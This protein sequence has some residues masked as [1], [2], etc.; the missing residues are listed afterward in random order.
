MLTWST[1]Y[2]AVRIHPN[3]CI[4]ETGKVP[5]LANGVLP[6]SPL[7][8]ISNRSV[9]VKAVQHMQAL[10][11]TLDEMLPPSPCF[12]VR[13]SPPDYPSAWLLPSSARFP[14]VPASV[15]PGK[16]I[17][18]LCRSTGRC[19]RR[20]WQPNAWD[21][22]L[23]IGEKNGRKRS[24]LVDGIGVP[25]SLAVS[26]ANTHDVKLLEATLDQV[27]IEMPSRAVQSVRGCGI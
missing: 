16:E 9:H 11:R 13:M 14:A 12:I 20:H 15:S 19:T 26:G 1:V 22:T 25:L 24:L 17:L 4:R 18:T 23:R 6:P 21:R 8:E 7:I 10:V 2:L 3:I 5:C 27:V